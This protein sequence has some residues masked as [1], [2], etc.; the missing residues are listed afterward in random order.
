MWWFLRFRDDHDHYLRLRIT[1]PDSRPATFG[2]TAAAVG[3]WADD[4][5][6]WGLLRDV[7]YATSYPQ[8]G[9]WG[10]GEAYTAAEAVFTA[11]SR[12][13]LAQ[14][15]QNQRPHR[16]ALAAAHFAA[17]ACAFT[18]STTAGMEWLI[19]HVPA[20]AP[21]PVPRP[22]FTEAVSVA[23]PHENFRALRHTPG[24]AAI[25]QAWHQRSTALATYRTH[26]PS[27]DTTGIQVDHVL[28]SLLHTH[29]LRACSIDAEEKAVCLYL[30]RAAALAYHS[31]RRENR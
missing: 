11:D 9:R 16:Q 30:A 26:F 31:R 29:F 4:L 18:G 23:D 19:N 17:I 10:G 1:L 28:D 5:Q 20:S 22:L 3:T 2:D 27:H 25:V 24:G 7:A 21:A 8:T 13:V 14:L 12:A 15:S 6:T